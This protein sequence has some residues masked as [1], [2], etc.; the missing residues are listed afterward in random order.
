MDARE[1]RRVK[2]RT[3]QPARRLEIP[4]GFVLTNDEICNVLATLNSRAADGDVDIGVQ[5]L[6]GEPKLWS[7]A[8]PVGAALSRD[9]ALVLLN[10][11]NRAAM[12]ADADVLLC[13]SG[14]H[15]TKKH[16]TLKSLGDEPGPALQV[17]GVNVRREF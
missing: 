9:E 16:L 17:G 15:L 8:M 3:P 11:C 5:L 1:P 12:H 2:K 6:P 4:E 10:I 7:L 14:G 13:W